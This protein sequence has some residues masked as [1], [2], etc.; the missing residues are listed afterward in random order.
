MTHLLAD[1]FRHFRVAVAESVHGYTGREVKISPVL[2]VPEK[3]AF[4]FHH[5]GRWTD[6]SWHHIRHMIIDDSGGLGIGGW[7]VVG[8]GSFFLQEGFSDA[9]IRFGRKDLLTWA[10]RI[11]SSSALVVG[12]A[13][14]DAGLA[15]RPARWTC[16][17]TLLFVAASNRLKAIRDA[18]PA[19]KTIQK[20]PII[21]LRL[22]EC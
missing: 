14:A 16:R 8:K 4:T 17:K 15:C 19:T 18:I 10:S 3:T 9:A 6:V 13:I 2:N 12:T 1:Q 11:K 5:H 22:R 20:K 7:I 21:Q